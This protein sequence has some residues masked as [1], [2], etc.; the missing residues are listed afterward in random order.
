MDPDESFPLGQR[1]ILAWTQGWPTHLLLGLGLVATAAVGMAD[2]G[3]ARLLGYDFVA[4]GF[5]MVPIGFVA[6]VGGRR[7]GMVIA[8]AAALTETVATYAALVDATNIW[9]VPIS[10]LLE[11]VVFVATAY[12]HGAIRRLVERERHLSRQDSVSGVVNSLGFREAAGWEVSR[13]RRWPQVV[14]L[15]YLDVD[16]FKAVND[17][18]GHA[19]GDEVLRIIGRAMKQSLR[20]SDVVARVGGDE[21]A[22]LMPGTDEEGCR[23]ATSRVHLAITRDLAEAGFAVTAS[24]GAT[25]F[26]SAPETVDEL[27]G[28]GDDAMFKV[29]RGSKNGVHH[30]VVRSPDLPPPDPSRARRIVTPG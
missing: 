21:F 1:A 29:K 23:A 7:N 6:F 5:Y 24:V 11:L 8:L 9:A 16:D 18:Q 20:E 15:I 4:T 26:P 13:A 10:I 12:S 17:Q 2:Y 22:A 27:I 30:F 19:R 14:S 3:V 25:T 28:A